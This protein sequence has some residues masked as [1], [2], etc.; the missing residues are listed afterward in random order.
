MRHNSNEKSTSV[1]RSDTVVEVI[2]DFVCHRRKNV[3]SIL[4]L[5]YISVIIISGTELCGRLNS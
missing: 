5:L 4:Y 2:R 1:E 3:N